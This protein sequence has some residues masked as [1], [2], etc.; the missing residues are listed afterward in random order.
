MPG[1]VHAPPM[2]PTRRRLLQCAA[3]ALAGLAGCSAPDRR[4]SPTEA[5]GGP[6]GPDGNVD[7]DPEGVSLR[8]RDEE[9]PAWL[10][11]ESTDD[12]ASQGPRGSYDHRLVA[13]AETADRLAFADV[14]GAE[15][16]RAF[17]EDFDFESS[18]LLLETGR[19]GACYRLGL[20]Y[21]AWTADEVETQYGSYL[22]DA[23][24]DC[25]AGEHRAVSWLIRIPAPL[26]PGEV[27]G[28]STGWSRSGCAPYVPPGEDPGEYLRPDPPVTAEPV[29]LENASTEGQR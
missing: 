14:D 17:V 21:V 24:V 7:R 29:P 18:T 5:A 6:G 3:G 10:R 28:H 27:T 4:S 8:G 9:A 22:R 25:E 13:D 2:V 11:P 16:A 23:D 26:D 15:D 1:A 20:C 12:D 19:A